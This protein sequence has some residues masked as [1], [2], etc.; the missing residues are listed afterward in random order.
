MIT[1]LIRSIFPN[2]RAIRKEYSMEGVVN[3]MKAYAEAGF[4]DFL[5][6]EDIPEQRIYEY[7]FISTD[8]EICDNFLHLSVDVYNKV[9]NEKHFNE[10]K[11]KEDAEKVLNKLKNYA[12]NKDYSDIEMGKAY[13]IGH[14]GIIYNQLFCPWN[15]EGM[16][17]IGNWFKTKEEAEEA[18][19]KL[20]EIY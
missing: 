6:L 1:D 4:G 13:F 19:N 18:L 12:R 14:N 9:I 15:V 16:K 8:G 2:R 7:F 5:F 20:K 17:S 11:T 10:F 3:K